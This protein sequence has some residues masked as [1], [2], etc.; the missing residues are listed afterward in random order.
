MHMDV[1]G[2]PKNRTCLSLDNS[3]MFSGIERRVIRQK[4][5]NV[6]KNKGQIRIVKHLNILCLICINICHPRNSAKFDCNTWI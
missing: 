4:F 5:Q 1:Q 3:E 2:G 6:A